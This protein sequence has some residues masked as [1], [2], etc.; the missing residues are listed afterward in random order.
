MGRVV[1]PAFGRLQRDR[2]GAV[3]RE[4]HA[5]VRDRERR[6]KVVP[7]PHRRVNLADLQLDR[8]GGREQSVVPLE[9][10]PK[11]AA[12]FSPRPAEVDTGSL[13][14]FLVNLPKGEATPYPILGSTGGANLLL[15][16]TGPMARWLP[17]SA[18]L[19]D[20]HVVAEVAMEA[21][22][23]CSGRQD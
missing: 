10:G 1:Q 14:A 4:P 11:E 18:Q 17:G 9:L 13:I 5:D 12:R 20:L 19:L 2:A 7:A 21:C 8:V 3:G 6:G 16:S 15:S 23:H 22:P